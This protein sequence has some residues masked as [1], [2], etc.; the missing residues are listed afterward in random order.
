M[1]N[2]PSIP[3][4][5]TLMKQ[6]AVTA[7]MTAWAVQILRDPAKYPM[8]S[9]V[10]RAFGQLNVL[11]RVEWHAPDFQN[12][13]LH[14]GVTLYAPPRPEVGVHTAEGIDISGYQ[15]NVDWAKIA[16][17]GL[18]FAFIKATEGTTLIDRTFVDHWAGAKQA[19]L[20]RGAY[21]FFRPKLD[22]TAQARFFLAQ[23]SDPGELP[24]V[25]D[26]E[27]VNGV[28]LAQVAASVGVWLDLVT[29][30]LGRPIVYTSPSFWNALPSP[31][32][33]ASKADLWVANWGARA[34]AAVHGWSKWTFW[35]FTNKATVSG[36]PGTADM[37][38]NRFCGS[39][40]DLRAYSDAFVASRHHPGPGDEQNQN[41]A[42]PNQSGPRDSANVALPAPQR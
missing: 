38:E 9:T 5:Y 2:S 40:A 19:K 41:V 36:I 32:D 18:S 30:Q 39:V 31:S 15:P 1:P 12:H 10:V 3:T 16:T 34:P 20:L 11:A 7:E 24:P 17:S 4:G 25:L 8:F 22:A 6:L 27:L 13:T 28:S 29:Q 35:Q 21:H 33:I 42:C 14:R 37:D 23:L 26:V